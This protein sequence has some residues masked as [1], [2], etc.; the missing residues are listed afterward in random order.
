MFLISTSV[1]LVQAT[2]SNSALCSSDI[3]S[4]IFSKD[5]SGMCTPSYGEVCSMRAARLATLPKMSY[6]MHVLPT[7]PEKMLPSARPMRACTRRPVGSFSPTSL[8]SSRTPNPNVRDLSTCWCESSGT[9]IS[10]I[11]PVTARYPSPTVRTF[12]T[13]RSSAILSTS[14]K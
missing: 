4:I 8:S 12:V 11:R 5:D 6:C 1:F 2:F 9:P 7:T 13:P 14:S 3:S 10:A